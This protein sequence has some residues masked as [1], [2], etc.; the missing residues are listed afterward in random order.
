MFFF[1]SFAR[2]ERE[3]EERRVKREAERQAGLVDPEASRVMHRHVHH[4]IHYHQSDDEDGDPLVGLTEEER[5]LIEMESEKSISQSFRGLF[6]SGSVPVLHTHSHLP[7]SELPEEFPG[8][9]EIRFEEDDDPL[10]LDQVRG[11]R[12]TNFI[13]GVQLAAG[14]YADNGKPVYR[15]RRSSQPRRQQPKQRPVKRG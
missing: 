10:G 14:T 2:K 13:R 1:S 6:G 7:A 8:N 12:C 3:K 4:H 5:R 11:P 15:K 9:S